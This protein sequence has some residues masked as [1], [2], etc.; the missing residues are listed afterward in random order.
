MA[1]ELGNSKVTSTKLQ[2]MHITEIYTQIASGWCWEGAQLSMGFSQDEKGLSKPFFTPPEDTGDPSV[3]PSLVR[4]TI[5]RGRGD[6]K[7]DQNTFTD[8]I[9]G[10]LPRLALSFS[11][12]LSLPLLLL[13]L[14]SLK[15]RRGDL[16]K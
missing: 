12:P 11:S 10:L 5:T 14:K 9:T 8:Q 1:V 4:G 7:P 2:Q 3:V 6:W 16:D 13:P 15:Q